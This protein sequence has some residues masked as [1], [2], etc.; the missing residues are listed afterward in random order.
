MNKKGE[1]IIG[2]GWR[3]E[4]KGLGFQAE[5]NTSKTKALWE[6]GQLYGAGGK[7]DEIGRDD[8]VGPFQARASRTATSAHCPAT[9]AGTPGKC[10]AGG[11]LFTVG[12]AE[13]CPEE[14][15]QLTGLE[16]KNGFF[17][18]RAF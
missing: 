16:K 12:A 9:R 7:R 8:L 3:K 15:Q 11:A 18:Q 6:L 17:P 13:R 1:Q 2:V 14:R 4:R 5:R 10:F